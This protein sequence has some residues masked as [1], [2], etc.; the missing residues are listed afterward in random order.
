ME[1][2]R[3]RVFAIISKAEDGDRAS[4]AFDIGI[5]ALIV[6]C[7]LSIVLESFHALSSRYGSLFRTFDVFSVAVFTLEYLARIWTARL[8]YPDAKHPFRKYILSPMAV[9]DLLAI[10]PFYLPLVSADLRFLR[11]LRLF[12][13][14]RLLRVFKLGRYLDSLHSI[15]RVLKQSAVQLIASVSA[16]A[17]LMLFASILM[18]AVE[19][20]AQP[21]AFPNV[22]AALWWAVCTLT[23]VGYGDVYP[24]T[25]LGKVLA[26]L[27]SVLGI[28]IVAVPT[29]IISAGFIAAVSETSAAKAEAQTHCPYCGHKLND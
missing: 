14:A 11:L 21:T 29:G 15:A 6:L 28:G 18:Y 4:R 2:Y 8:L 3:R 13:M 16:C 10:A 23:T 26:S 25:T 12:R 17:V 24:I 27:I 5:V 7:V 22:I 19:N 9:I 1:T 20:P